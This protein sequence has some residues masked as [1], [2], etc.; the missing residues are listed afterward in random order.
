MGVARASM[1]EI[2]FDSLACPGGS[3]RSGEDLANAAWALVALVLRRA[4]AAGTLA[5]SRK[6][7]MLKW[8]THES[9]SLAKTATSATKEHD[10]D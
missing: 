5:F 10:G 1:S 4:T 2:N 9:A 6:P 7:C 8:N 3:Q